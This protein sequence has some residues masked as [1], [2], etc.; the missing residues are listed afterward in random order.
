[1]RTQWLA[2]PAVHYRRLLHEWGG[3]N[4]AGDKIQVAVAIHIDRVS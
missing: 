1:M 2:P 4:A 3:A